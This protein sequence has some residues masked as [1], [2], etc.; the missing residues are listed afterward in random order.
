MGSAFNT[1]TPNHYTRP[2]THLST[3]KPVTSNHLFEKQCSITGNES[4]G[5]AF[6]GLIPDIIFISSVEILN[7]QRNVNPYKP[8]VAFSTCSTVKLSLHS[9][10]G[11]A[12][13][14][15]FHHFEQIAF[16]VEYLVWDIICIFHT[17][18]GV[19]HNI[20]AITGRNP[21][22]EDATYIPGAQNYKWFYSASGHVKCLM[23]MTWWD[24]ICTKYL[25]QTLILFTVIMLQ[26]ELIQQVCPK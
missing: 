21:V 11:V 22:E 15:R 17:G 6:S 8:Q 2:S 7:V 23:Q 19:E 26:W 24:I 14:N 1:E 10:S 4:K 3:V 20:S 9:I 13:C 12:V 18:Q 5:L 16:S 25:P